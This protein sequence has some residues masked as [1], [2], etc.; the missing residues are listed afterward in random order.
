MSGSP[1]SSSRQ[2]SDFANRDSLEYKN[3]LGSTIAALLRVVPDGALVFF[4]TYAT[5]AA[6]IGHWKVGRNDALSY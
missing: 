3:E 1:C 5:M 2:R 6:C 4:A